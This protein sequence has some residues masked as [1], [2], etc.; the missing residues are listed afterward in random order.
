LN[1]YKLHIAAMKKHM[2]FQVFIAMNI[3]TVDLRIKSQCILIQLLCFWAL[4]II[5]FLFKTH[6]ISET[7][8]CL[9][10]QVEPT[11][12]GAFEVASHDSQPCKPSHNWSP[13]IYSCLYR[14]SYDVSWI[15]NPA[16]CE[17]RAI[18]RFLHAKNLRAVEIHHELCMVY[19][20]NGISEETV[21]Q[22]CTKFKDGQT[23]VHNEE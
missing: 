20:Q 6:N 23:N 9:G 14:E 16:S 22:W 2:I 11:Q 7:G 18:I 19:G 1:P 12:L 10:L 3:H 17:I 15:D 13:S 5:L 21:R 8:F 4:S